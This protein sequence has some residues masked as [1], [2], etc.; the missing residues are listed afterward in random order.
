[1]ECGPGFRCQVRSLMP[2][3]FHTSLGYQS[4]GGCADLDLRAW[5]RI[6]SLHLRT[7]RLKIPK[8]QILTKN[9]A[10]LFNFIKNLG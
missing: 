2:Y 4:E 3:R 5:I 10:N 9:G 7:I 1:M 8:V 6:S